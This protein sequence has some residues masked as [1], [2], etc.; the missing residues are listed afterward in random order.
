MKDLTITARRLKIELC[1]LI[2]SFVVANLCNAGAIWYYGASY[3]EMFTSFFYVLA[4]TVFIYL[5]TVVIRIIAAGV[6]A[7]FRFRRIQ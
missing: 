5:L 4:F 6:C 3:K 2:G 7:L 1:C